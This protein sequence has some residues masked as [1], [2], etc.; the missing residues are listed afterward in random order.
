M[1]YTPEGGS[2]QISTAKRGEQIAIEIAD[3]GCG[4]ASQDLPYIFE[5]FYRGQP[6][7]LQNSATKD[8]NS[9]DTEECSSSNETSGIGLGLYLVH[10]LVN[11]IGGEILAESPVDDTRRGTR[12]T[13]LLPIYADAV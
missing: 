7:N 12:F 1:K 11:E 13:V 5:K 2:I 6:L 4:I 10:S 9:F 8:D 3:T